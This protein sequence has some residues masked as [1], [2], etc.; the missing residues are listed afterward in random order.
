MAV[1]IVTGKLGGGKTL[2]SVKRIRDKLEQ[3]CII[4]TNLDLNL[5]KLISPFNKTARVYRVPDKPTIHDLKMIGHGTDSY[6]E[7]E[8]G[9]LVLDECGTWF[10][11][12]NW[13]DKKRV[14]VNEWFLHARKLGW[15]VIL[16]IQDVGNLDSQARSSIAE[17]TVF[18]KRTDRMGIPGL[19]TLFKLFTGYRLRLPR[20]HIGRV[21]Y[22]VN[23]TDMFIDRWATAGTGLFAAY[24]TKQAFI[25]DYPNGTHSILPPWYNNGRYMAARNAR[26]YMRVT[27][28][29]WKRFKSP[30]ALGAGML[31]GSSM[32]IAA[33]FATQYTPVVTYAEPL[34]AA[35]FTPEPEPEERPEPEPVLVA[36][37]KPLDPLLESLSEM[38]INGYAALG[39][40][41]IYGL[42][43]PGRSEVA[44]YSN[45]LPP[46][47]AIEKVN[48]CNF[49]VYRSQ[50]KVSVYCF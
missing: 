6:D 46:A 2:I 26:F 20:A 23:P 14:P 39:D 43:L 50:Q 28:I 44:F 1:Y 41:I 10:N 5:E 8:N 35:V 3:H 25:D 17:H 48:S 34:P 31:I 13:Q 36:E 33:V 30:V 21:V 32:A 37:P 40:V 19:S 27:K 49:N 29:F 7:S 47:Y 15:D 22:G 45:E 42:S 12:R 24:D 18:C 9:L 4:A 16:I 11:S 38:R